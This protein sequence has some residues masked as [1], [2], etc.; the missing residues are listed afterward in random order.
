VDR[1][2]LCLLLSELRRYRWGYA[3]RV[4][5]ALRKRPAMS[6]TLV[7]TGQHYDRRLSTIV[8]RSWR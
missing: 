1:R 2:R 3:A 8:S 4:I 6:V 7:H 5:E